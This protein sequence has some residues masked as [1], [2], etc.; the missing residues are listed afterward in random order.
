MTA[1]VFGTNHYAQKIPDANNQETYPDK[2]VIHKFN[3]FVKNF[4]TRSF[5]NLSNILVRLLSNNMQ[6]NQKQRLSQLQIAY[7]LFHAL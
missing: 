3:Y 5:L 7:L 1:D 2:I 6:Q 4:H